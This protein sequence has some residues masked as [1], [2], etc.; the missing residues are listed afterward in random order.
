MPIGIPSPRGGVRAVIKGTKHYY[1]VTRPSVV[2]MKGAWAAQPHPEPNWLEPHHDHARKDPNNG[3]ACRA[4]Q[5]PTWPW[6]QQQAPS[7]HG[8]QPLSRLSSTTGVRRVSHSD[9]LNL[10]KVDVTRELP[11]RHEPDPTNEFILQNLDKRPFEMTTTSKQSRH[12][13]RPCILQRHHG[14]SAEMTR[15]DGRLGAVRERMQ[16]TDQPAPE[17]TILI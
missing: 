16:D 12:L 10:L 8:H 5:N 7:L 2:R 17:K 3:E 15:V 6:N 13:R 9:T 14:L 4:A 1:P 11:T